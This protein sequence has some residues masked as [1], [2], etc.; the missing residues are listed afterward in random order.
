MLYIFLVIGI[1]FGVLVAWGKILHHLD[2]FTIDK[3]N[4]YYLF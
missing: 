1:D 2:A 4:E 3:K